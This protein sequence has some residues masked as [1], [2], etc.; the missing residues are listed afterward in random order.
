[1]SVNINLRVPAVEKL[2]DYTASGIGAVAGP[3]LASWKARKYAEATLIEAEAHADSLKLIAGAQSEA[4]NL[5][6]TPGET[7]GRVLEGSPEGFTQRLEFQERKRQ[8]NITSVI[9][10]A[11]TNLGDK[12][13]PD[14]APDPDWVARFFN[15]VQD[16][17]S[18]DMKKIWATILSGEIENP[19]RTSLR[20]LDILKNMTAKDA[21]MF[22]SMCNF[23]TN[24]F[25]FYPD[26]YQNHHV[27]SYN[28]V[29]HLQDSGLLNAQPFLYT[30]LTFGEHSHIISI[31][32]K[33]LILQVI[34]KDGQK[35]VGIPAIILTS[36]GK[37]LYQIVKCEP[38]MDHLQSLST[39]LSGENCELS[40][41]YYVKEHPDGKN[42]IFSPLVT[43]K[44]K[45]EQSDDIAS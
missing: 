6:A 34:S 17:S 39:F 25:I 41:A 42:R 40:Y 29:I 30:E 36:S 23:V 16:I 15:C 18:E 10:E 3:M 9:R 37:E 45:H 28:R 1:M 35:K 44:P 11:A 22:E 27:L 12:D 21:Q 26:Q 4:H 14:H 8:A 7:G 24:D 5:L 38:H 19:G 31:E 32:C 33:N 20:T 43:I 2:V 13:V